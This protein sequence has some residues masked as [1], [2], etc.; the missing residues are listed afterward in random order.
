VKI[1]P[2]NITYATITLQ[3]YFRM[4]AKL[5][6]MTGTALTEAE[7][8]YKI[9]KLDVL[10]IPMNLEY[11]AAQN[12]SP[13]VEVQARDEDNY[14]YSYYAQRS[15][16]ERKPIYYRR[17][18]FPDV[19]FR[20]EEAKLRQ[21][22]LEIIKF[23]VVGRPQL[24][25]TTSVEHSERLSN[26]L[27]AEPIRRLLQ[28]M[29]LRKAWMDK[30][31]VQIVE[32]AIP[33]LAFMNKPLLELE[34]GEMRPL[35]RT[36][37]LTLNL[38]EQANL[39]ILLQVLELKPQH[40]PRLIKALQGGI[41]HAVLNAKK[42]DEESLII[43]RAGAFGA[44]T[45]ATNMAGRGVDIRLGGELPDEVLQD[46]IRVLVKAG[47]P[48]PYDLTNEERRQALLKIPPE[49]YGIYEESVR[50]FMQ[51]LE[52][53]VAVRAL[54]GLHVIGSERHEAR[55]IDNQLRGRAARQGDPGSSRF[56]LSMEDE[57][58]RLFGGAQGEN[59]MRRLNLDDMVPIESGVLGRL[60]E[61]SQMRV[62]GSNFDVR[63]HLLEYDD[64]LN[65]QRK[66]IYSQR[67]LV[68]TKDDLSED[69]LE[70]L[71]LE[72]KERVPQ[73]LKDEE[74]PWKLLGFLEQIQPPIDFEDGY[75][76]SYTLNLLLGDIQNRMKQ[77]VQ[78]L[79]AL[80][81]ALLGLA[82]EAFDAER[83]HVERGARTMLERTSESLEAQL[84]EHLDAL[85]A[86]FSTVR[87]G[88]D[89]EETPRLR[90]PQEVL[91]ELTNA[92]RMPLRLNS[93]QMRLLVDADPSLED[94][95]RRQIEQMLMAVAINRSLATLERRLEEPLNLKP[96][97]LM[98]L[99][100]DEAAGQ[101]LRSVE[102]VY[103][104]RRARL[105]G[106]DG[107]IA[108]ELENSV[109]RLGDTVL[110]PRYQ[111]QLLRLMSVGQRVDF[112]TRTHRRSSAAY[113]RLNFIYYAARLLEN[114]PPELVTRDVLDHLLNAQT[115]LQTA[116][117]LAEWNRLAMA[118][119]SL[120]QLEERVRLPMLDLVGEEHFTELS[121][122]PMIEIGAADRDHLAP[123]L[124][125]RM[126]N[127]IYRQLL[128]NVISDQW[129]EYLTKVEALRV[130]IGME[131]YAQRDPLVAYKGQASELFKVLLT[132]IRMGV[133]T[134]MFTVQPRRSNVANVEREAAEPEAGEQGPDL[135]NS[136]PAED[137]KKKR[138]RH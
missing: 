63:K 98:E 120:S 94:P 11:S 46:A 22:S 58:M 48:D 40:T 3:N 37:G 137:R 116:W 27:E 25:G 119:V 73:N 72:L 23:H 128:L 133:I 110:D 44:V 55:R 5:A 131:A 132:D 81:D 79:T 17:K 13:L 82:A 95:L 43:A 54:G 102:N 109:G 83:E 138:R 67:D 21:I 49:E 29:L 135:A 114:T 28:V 14:K 6:G 12:E 80:Q 68:F 69:V 56:F 70:M 1:E 41:Q 31:N 91:D 105:L 123:V 24:I 99:S 10:P 15:D 35:A 53:M 9:Y 134:R 108:R 90:R 125:K 88:Q 136:T 2:E 47:V 26:R 65:S 45:I 64:V 33:E 115:T 126:Q 101:M 62:E 92:V 117:G 52:D 42:H 34:A 7:E 59:L 112:D 57:L 124:G 32:R 89:D 61:Q 113:N 127:E 130:S 87:D 75:C 100:W 96:S 84:S 129:V 71:E 50:A 118:G 104:N 4:Y 51:Y 19:V 76:P 97:A 122:L 74:G 85:D 121:V 93:D 20:S 107:Q 78:P 60:V 77:G 106:R 30:N 18:D 111:I 39:D 36:L 16:L 8:F 66:R 86:F 38:E 103:D